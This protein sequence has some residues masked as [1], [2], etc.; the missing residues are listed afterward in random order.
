MRGHVFVFTHTTKWH[1]ANR[2]LFGSRT[3]TLEAKVVS[4]PATGHW[5]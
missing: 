1:N 3:E 4:L 5:T 2:L